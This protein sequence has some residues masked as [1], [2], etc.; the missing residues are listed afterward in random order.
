[1]FNPPG[2]RTEARVYHLPPGP[3]PLSLTRLSAVLEE[4][5]PGFRIRT[6]Q[7]S[8]VP[9]LAWSAELQSPASAAL[10]VWF[11]PRTGETLAEQPEP[12]IHLG[13]LQPLVQTASHFHGDAAAGI[14]LLS[15]PARA[16][17][18][19]GRG[20]YSRS[21]GRFHLPPGQISS[22]TMRSDSIPRSSCCSFRRPPWSCPCFRARPWRSSVVSPIPRSDQSARRGGRP[23]S[24]RPVRLCRCDWTS[25][26]RC[27]SPPG[28]TRGSPLPSSG[29]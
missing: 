16:W 23:V 9:D 18:C 12:V 11:N 21:G 14:A 8:P 24:G 4:K 27:K 22:C 2:S 13:W 25:T 1:M 6:M 28:C 19:G 10:T 3:G 20:G 7:F 26:R 15:W 5:Y 29:G 17:S